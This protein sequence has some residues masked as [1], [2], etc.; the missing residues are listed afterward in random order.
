MLCANPI[1]VNIVLANVDQSVTVV[2]RRPNVRPYLLGPEGAALLRVLQV[3]PDDVGLLEE[4]AHG[5]GQLRVLARLGVRQLGRRM[6]TRGNNILDQ[7]YCNIAK[8]PLPPSGPI[9]SH[10]SALNTCIQTPH[11]KDQTNSS[12]HHGLARRS[13]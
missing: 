7:V 1:K 10:Q 11:C 2:V 3:V 9:R 12:H 13:Q 8:V 6:P 4:Q 5:A